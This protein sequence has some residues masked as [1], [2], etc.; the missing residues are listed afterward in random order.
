MNTSDKLGKI[1]SEEDSSF[2]DNILH[3]ILQTLGANLVFSIWFH[4]MKFDSHR[5]NDIVIHD[6]SFVVS[7]ASC[8]YQPSRKGNWRK[9]FS[10]KHVHN[11]KILGIKTCMIE[12]EA[13]GIYHK[14]NEE[15]I[16]KVDFDWLFKKEQVIFL[17][18][19]K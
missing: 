5:N 18:I 19:R 8:F 12:E 7:V 17:G 6:D 14:R 13:Q 4:H 1:L 2:L 16:S 3:E 10:K 9:F 15:T 11:F